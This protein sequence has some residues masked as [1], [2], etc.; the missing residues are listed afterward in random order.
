MRARLSRR[1]GTTSVVTDPLVLA[2]VMS[3]AA[4]EAVNRCVRFIQ[5]QTFRPTGVLVVDNDSPVR[6]DPAMLCLTGEVPVRVLPLPENLGPAGGYA[7]GFAAALETNCDYLWVMDDD[8][9]PASDCLE[10]L[11]YEMLRQDGQA[12][13]HPALYSAMTGEREDHWGFYG[14]LIPRGAVERAGVPFDRFFICLEDTE[15]LRDRLPGAGYPGV[16]VDDATVAAALRPPDVSTPAWKYYYNSRNHVF[17]YL[18]MRPHLP[19]ISRIKIELYFEYGEIQRIMRIE[20][21]RRDK[22][23]HLLRGVF[24]GLRGR[25]GRTLVPDHPDRPWA[26]KS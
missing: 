18:R 6:P 2:I 19:M 9:M 12:H 5:R 16:L 14:V 23:V 8:C 26:L 21:D 10:L 11:M 13:A 7:A 22:L 20:D 17:F 15:Y 25:M 3:Y 1:Q 24:D 4:P